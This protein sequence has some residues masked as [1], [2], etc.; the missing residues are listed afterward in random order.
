MRHNFGKQPWLYPMPVLIVSAYGEDGTPEAMAIGWCGILDP[1]HLSLCLMEGHKTTEAI[2]KTGAFT[3]AVADEAH[4]AACDYVGSVSGHKVKDKVARA[5]FHTVK[6]DF[7]N[8]PIIEELPVT[9][10]CRL[11]R[12]DPDTGVMIGQ[13]VNVSASDSAVDA[14]GHIDADRF[15]ALTYDPCR[16]GYRKLGSFLGTATQVCDREMDKRA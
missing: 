6:S 14:A 7:V 1:Q 9:L 5:G 13:I 3:A 8:A 2:L 10:E 15:C 4:L 12:F 16:N 11:E